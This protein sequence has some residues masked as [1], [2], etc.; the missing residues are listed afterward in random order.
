MRR[1]LL[2]LSLLALGTTGCV[3]KYDGSWLI[4]Y[5]LAEDTQD[6]ENNWIGVEQRMMGDFYRTKDTYVLSLGGIVLTG[7]KDGDNLDLATSVGMDNSGDDCSTY[8]IDTEQLF[9]G[10]FTDDMGLTGDLEV[11][12]SLRIENCP[13]QSDT[14]L[15]ESMKWDIEGVQLNSHSGKHA[16][17]ANWGYI[18]NSIY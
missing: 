15:V 18:P 2:L 1:L 16:D 6:P 10:Q 17:S 7:P 3:S 12:Q 14:N 4:F 5:T 13:P 9:G 11:R 8:S